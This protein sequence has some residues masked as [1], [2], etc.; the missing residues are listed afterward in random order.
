M[1]NVISTI[2]NAKSER[3]GQCE[4]SARSTKEMVIQGD[5]NVSNTESQHV[6]NGVEKLIEIDYV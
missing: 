4:C 2:N 5:K 3:Y 6:I 1:N